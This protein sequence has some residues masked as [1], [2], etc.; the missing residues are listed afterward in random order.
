MSGGKLEAVCTI[1][2]FDGLHIGHRY[3]LDQ[4][5]G[6]ARSL[7]LPCVALSFDHDPEEAFLPP[8]K[9]QHLLSNTERLELLAKSGVDQVIV[10][11][12]DHALAALTATE[13]L[14][15]VLGRLLAPKSIHVGADFRFG[16][17]AQGDV[18]CLKQWADSRE[19]AVFGHQLLG[20]GGQAVSASRI[21]ACLAD[22]RLD[23]ANQLLGRP[24][25]LKGR[26]VRGRGVGNSLGFPTANIASD[27]GVVLP[28]DGV[29]AGLVQFGEVRQTES[30]SEN[31]RAAPSDAPPLPQAELHAAAIS[32]GVP[33]SFDGVAASLEAF[34]LDYQGDLYDQ[35]L[36]LHFLKYL[37]PMQVFGDARALSQQISDDV[38]QTRKLA[39]QYEC[40]Q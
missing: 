2:V 3:L 21:R 1:G 11:H 23:E 20:D 19:V 38:R 27:D 18:A 37:R 25:H 5:I 33:L 14:D 22:G 26:V 36:R 16:A 6:D 15:Q 10:L 32:V 17:A 9:V 28:A 31:G 7:G 30:V 35:E 12:F 34:L 4:A 13:F 8:E 29:Y 40:E 39:A 24:H